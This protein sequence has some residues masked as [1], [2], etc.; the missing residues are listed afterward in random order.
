MKVIY[1]VFPSLETAQE[2]CRVLVAKRLVSCANIIPCV[3]S[4]YWWD[5]SVCENQEVI[6]L[7]KTCLSNEEMVYQE[8]SAL[9]PY[10]C[11]ALFSVTPD[12]VYPDF[13]KW[14]NT[15]N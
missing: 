15:W 9:H 5:D 2:I 14:V 6:A 3:N 7:L 4:I 8:L 1:T 10:D 13:L 12:R 11:P